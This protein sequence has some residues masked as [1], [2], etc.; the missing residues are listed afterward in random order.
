MGRKGDGVD[1]RIDYGYVPSES[2][3]SIVV[4]ARPVT[5][6]QSGFR[7][8][9]TWHG[10][11]T[12]MGFQ[13]PSS[14]TKIELLMG[15][16]SAW[17]IIT[18]TTDLVADVWSHWAGTYDGTNHL[19]AN[20]T[21][22]GTPNTFTSVNST[23]DILTHDSVTNGGREFDGIIAELLITDIALTTRQVAA[24]AR[25]VNPFGM[26]ARNFQTY[27]PI[28]G[29]QSPEPDY[30]G[31]HIGTLTGTTRDKH[32]PIEPMENYL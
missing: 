2:P 15:T 14:S 24:L 28:H 6:I 23:V 22:E 16:G 10:G 18:S 17:Q 8:L 25:G 7:E 32:P 20:G 29:N 4:W 27:S 19:Y 1:D 13:K 5:S 31:S 21:E 11:Q 30:E 26:V 3:A 12:G 9:A